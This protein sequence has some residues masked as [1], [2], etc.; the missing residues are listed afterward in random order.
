[1]SSQWPPL[2]ARSYVCYNDFQG[3]YSLWKWGISVFN[4]C[5]TCTAQAALKQ[6]YRIH[7]LELNLVCA[8]LKCDSESAAYLLRTGAL[9]IMNTD[10]QIWVCFCS[11]TLCIENVLGFY[12]TL[13]CLPSRT[14]CGRGTQMTLS[15]SDSPFVL[16]QSDNS[17]SSLNNT[18]TKGGPLKQIICPWTILCNNG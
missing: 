18:D 16:Q 8:N 3:M 9:Q 10:T 15:K 12:S 7:N 6:H 1:V 13:C 5:K 11:K 4:Y 14:H 2:N 17:M